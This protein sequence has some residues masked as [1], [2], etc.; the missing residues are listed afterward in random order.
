MKSIWKTIIHSVLLTAAMNVLA[1]I[2]GQMNA[3]LIH[4]IMRWMSH[5][6]Y[7]TFSIV[8]ASVMNRQAVFMTAAV[9]FIALAVLKQ[10]GFQA[11]D[12]LFP[13][14]GGIAVGIGVQAAL[15]EAMGPPVR[16]V[17]PPAPPPRGGP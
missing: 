10:P 15:Q 4:Q 17:P 14:A 3:P 5:W 11:L 12:L 1:L 16:P 7:F 2:L 8:A 6:H 13:I 9:I